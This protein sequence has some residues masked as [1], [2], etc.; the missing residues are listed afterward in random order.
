MKKD[1]KTIARSVI[2]K[3]C[4]TPV[5]TACLV[6]NFHAETPGGFFRQFVRENKT[7]HHFLN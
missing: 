1:F 3:L 2:R 7:I 5:G 6:F 4:C